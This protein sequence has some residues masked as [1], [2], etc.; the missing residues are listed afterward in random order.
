M[1]P[2]RTLVSV[3]LL[4]ATAASQCLAIHNNPPGTNLQMGDDSLRVLA[5]P[6][7]FPF[8]G[9]A[10][11]RVTID[12]NGTVRLGD[13]SLTNPS[14]FSPT[15]AE[16]RNDPHATI[17]LLWDDW[18]VNQCASGDGIFFEADTTRAS[19]VFKNVPQ[20]G[21]GAGLLSGEVVLM[22][23]G[24]IY[25]HY[26]PTSTL[27]SY[28]SCIAGLSRGY[29][30][31]SNSFDPI[32]AVSIADSTGYHVFDSASKQFELA[33][34]TF[35]VDP[36][37][38][39]SYSLAKAFPPACTPP[40]LVPG[41]AEGAIP[42][43]VGC[44]TPISNGSLYEQFTGNAGIRPFDL[45]NKSLEFVHNDGSYSL[46]QG[47]GFATDYH[48]NGAPLPGVDD[49][50]QHTVSLG[51]MGSF[52]FGTMPAATAITVGA[53]GYIWLPAGSPAYTP[54]AAAFHSQ[55]A[56]IAAAWMDLVP[57]ATTAPIWWES[58]DPSF[59][60]ATWVAAPAFGDGGA[61][62]FQVT[63]KSNGN[64][65]L[66]YAACSMG[67]T[68]A[69][70][71]GI[72]GGN[73]AVDQGQ[74]DLWAAGSAQAASRRITGLDAMAHSANRIQIGTTLRLD[75][76]IPDETSFFGLFVFGLSSPGISLDSYGMTGCVQ[77]S[78]YELSYFPVF[79]TPGQGMSLQ[80]PIA[81]DIGYGIELYS[82]G[83]AWSTLNPFGVIVSNGLHHK[84][85]L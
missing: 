2:I 46:A 20:K 7:V 64:V 1:H 56:R 74:V 54:V 38:V 51:A 17:A 41:I 58:H 39:G 62:T 37:G 32:S 59:C 34:W 43:G 73:R 26:E 85:G 72:S 49:D 70:I 5:L 80:L 19:V 36:T 29:G 14:D 16:L 57:N 42:I 33:G 35:Q 11:D 9:V 52:R 4:A 77:H 8:H 75:A 3:G 82:Q 69:P 65:V 63:L 22:P 61:N 18:A 30:A 60:R 81:Y 71:V 68:R 83:A 67:A 48:V 31:P 76:T 84:V 79:F 44:P 50:S 6:F 47:P 24:S 12:S 10:Y 40:L 28:G 45:A 27:P 66:S 15:T 53:N 25:L 23:D 13:S 78:S 21:Y 55:G